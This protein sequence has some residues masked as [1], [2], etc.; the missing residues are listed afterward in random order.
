MGIVRSLRAGLDSDA[1]GRGSRI[2]IGK[3]VR[4]QGVPAILLAVACVVAAGGAMAVLEKAVPLLPDT[5]REANELWKTVRGDRSR[6][7]TA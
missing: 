2:R 5:L 6:R 1:L 4:V 7:L 3:N